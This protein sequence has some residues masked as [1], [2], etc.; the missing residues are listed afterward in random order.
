MEDEVRTQLPARERLRVYH[1][2]TDG[3]IEYYR[4][5]GL[6]RDIQGMGEIE[7]IYEQILQVLNQA[8]PTC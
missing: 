5:R 3:L 8:K 4:T 1:E 7:Q 2:N 6:L